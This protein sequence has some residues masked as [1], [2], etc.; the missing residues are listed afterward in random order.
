MSANPAPD[1][2]VP[3]SHACGHPDIQRAANPALN[4]DPDVLGAPMAGIVI[5]AN[6]DHTSGYA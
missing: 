2:Q 5:A 6:D 3:R 1:R 4:N